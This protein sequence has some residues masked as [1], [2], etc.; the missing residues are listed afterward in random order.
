MAGLQFKRTP[1]PAPQHLSATFWD[2]LEVHHLSQ[3]EICL[4]SASNPQCLSIEEDLV[5]SCRLSDAKTHH[6]MADN[7][8]S[9]VDVLQWMNILLRNEEDNG[10]ELSNQLPASV[11]WNY[12]HSV[13]QD[14]I[15]SGDY[16]LQHGMEIDV[17][18][19]YLKLG[20][21][22]E[23]RTRADPTHAHM[24]QEY[25]FNSIQG[26]RH[27]GLVR[28]GTVQRTGRTFTLDAYNSVPIVILV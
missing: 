6:W 14:M 13:V 23:K 16:G 7:V 22:L 15:A 11:D 8:D 18:Q 26:W 24:W 19:L 10:W 28:A 12:I 3:A 20:E 4:S 21:E 25:A 2:E 5:K 27:E 9:L 17:R 1:P